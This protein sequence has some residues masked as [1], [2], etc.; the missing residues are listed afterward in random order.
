MQDIEPYITF[1]YKCHAGGIYTLQSGAVIRCS[2]HGS[3]PPRRGPRLWENEE[4]EGDV[5]ARHSS[6]EFHEASGTGNGTAAGSD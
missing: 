4:K 3:L 5:G 1:E 6:I 2:V